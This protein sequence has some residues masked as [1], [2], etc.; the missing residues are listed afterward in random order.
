M[1]V[2]HYSC[3][4]ALHHNRKEIWLVVKLD[5]KLVSDLPRDSIL[6]YSILFYSILLFLSVWKSLIIHL[7]FHLEEH[8]FY[9][10]PYHL[11]QQIIIII[12][13]VIKTAWNWHKNRDI[14]QWNRTDSPEINLRLY[15]QL[16]FDKGGRSM[17][18]SKNSLFNNCVG[19]AGQ[20]CAKR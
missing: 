14:D 19:R 11:K 9:L 3:E 4:Y 5:F 2:Q 6:F 20:L 12:A 10:M 18:W 8:N 15:G 17:K 16:I 13:T 1:E 7:S